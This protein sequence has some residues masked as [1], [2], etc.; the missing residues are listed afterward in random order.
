MIGSS[1]IRC[2]ALNAVSAE[3]VVRRAGSTR[4]PACFIPSSLVL[5][6]NVAAS[7]WRE[8]SSSTLSKPR[9][10]W[11]ASAYH[12]ASSKPARVCA[13][14]AA[15]A[16]ADRSSSQEARAQTV[17]SQGAPIPTRRILCLSNGH[18]EDA[19]AVAIL[20][21]LKVSRA[22]NSARGLLKNLGALKIYAV[23]GWPSLGQGGSQAIAHQTGQKH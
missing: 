10:G 5:T 15:I 12:T 13:A 20:K 9:S 17:G 18:G 22:G 11:L 23:A 14:R 4:F 19:I 2:R 16:G 3:N 6:K 21:A 1:S 7:H 8:D